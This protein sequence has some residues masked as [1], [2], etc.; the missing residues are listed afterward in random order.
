MARHNT[1]HTHSPYYL[2]LQQIV[3]T[4]AAAFLLV[5]ACQGG[6]SPSPTPF[7]LNEIVDAAPGAE[8]SSNTVTLTGIT[9]PVIVTATGGV[10]VSNTPASHEQNRGTT[11]TLAPNA[12]FHV[13]ANAPPLPSQEKVIR[14]SAGN[15]QT[16]WR[17]RA[18]KGHPPSAA[19]QADT[20]ISLAAG[21]ALA[22]ANLTAEASTDPDQDI[23]GYTWTN[24]QGET[25]GNTTKL[26]LNLSA[27]S[28]LIT[29]QVTDSENN[30]HQTQATITVLPSAHQWLTSGD[31]TH[32]LTPLKEAPWQPL[33]A[34]EAHDGLPLTLDTTS[35]L[36]SIEGLGFAL[37]QGSATAF[38][39]LPKDTRK[40]L[41]EELFS[42]Q[43]GLGI[44]MLRITVGASD[45]STSLY[46]Y[47]NVA[48]DTAMLHFSLEGPDS[49]STFVVLQEILA[50]NPTIK[51]LASPWSAPPWMK[52]NN[53]WIG[54]SLKPEYYAAYARYLVRYFDEMKKMGIN[55]WGL[56]PQNEPLHAGNE[57]SMAMS[58]DEQLD[59]INN[60]LGPALTQSSHTLKILAYDHNC[61]H[62]EYAITV[63]NGSPYVAGSAFHLYGGDISAL[64]H[65]K[66]I[67]QKDVFFTEQWTGAGG[68][69][70]GDFGWHMEN[71]VIGATRN[72][73]R[74]VL[75]WNLASTPPSLARG[76]LD[77]QGAVS[78]NE[79]THS[80]TRHV[81]Y[82]IIGQLSRFLPSGSTRIK[83]SDGE[84]GIF[85]VAFITPSGDI[86]LLI[87]N[88]TDAAQ[89]IN[90]LDQ[91]SAN[92]YLPIAVPGRSALTLSWQ[93]FMLD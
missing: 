82:Y 53:S 54:G 39:Q 30:Q 33:P 3:A 83:S 81:S 14:V 91:Q 5:T 1:F 63:A 4:L 45:L 10:I 69:F 64:T 26:S 20:F 62:P 32:K 9:T 80:I 67:T 71:I 88:S 21:Q 34:G 46:S 2:K 27:G 59:F 28:H 72:W 19:I 84:N 6:G 86:T 38:L 42:S 65:V 85:N 74:T 22:T 31:Q 79:E 78:I 75:E 8:L 57:P 87:Y 44:S 16:A 12:Q 61:D 51:L 48:D 93:R 55:F 15:F 18:A 7:E 76:C 25:L 52:T 29:L 37:T 43:T 23:T 41:L 11:L 17:I 66:D 40:A 70:D 60:H 77:C 73:A 90:V 89:S 47:N 35:R 36:Q 50:I 56:T 13:V 24:D 68:S 49:D 58:A 92:A